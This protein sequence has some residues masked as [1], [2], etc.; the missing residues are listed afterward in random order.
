MFRK[1]DFVNKIKSFKN[2]KNINRK[3]TTNTIYYIQ[4]QEMP[5]EYYKKI[6]KYCGLTFSY[7]FY[8][9]LLGDVDEIHKKDP[10]TLYSEKVVDSFFN[11]FFYMAPPVFAM[12]MYDL[13][14][15]I[16]IKLSGKNKL[17]YKSKYREFFGTYNYN[18]I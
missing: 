15:R 7:G 6:F 1:I 14:G 10:P 18:T 2:I 5:T 8:R 13:I 16:E 4:P 11:G 9:N 12:K 3:F 17:E